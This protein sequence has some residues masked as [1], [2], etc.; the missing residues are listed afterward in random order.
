MMLFIHTKPGWKSRLRTAWKALRGKP[1]YDV[2]L[3]QQL[4]AFSSASNATVTW[5]KP[6]SE[7]TKRLVRRHWLDLADRLRL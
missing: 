2:T 7:A 3:E 5:T 6:P 4:D 1:L